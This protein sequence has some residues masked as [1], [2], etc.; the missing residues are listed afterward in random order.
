MPQRPFALNRQQWL[1][2]KEKKSDLDTAL[3]N[4]FANAK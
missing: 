4:I 1:S 3:L 2:V